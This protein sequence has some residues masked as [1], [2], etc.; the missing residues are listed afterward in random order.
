MRPGKEIDS[1]TQNHLGTLELDH[2]GSF[3]GNPNPR[4]EEQECDYRKSGVLA[5]IQS[6][7]KN[8]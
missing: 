8:T 3:F 4:G 1:L 5:K 2:Q 7:V 6:Y